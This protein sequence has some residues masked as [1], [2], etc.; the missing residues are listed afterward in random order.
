MLLAVAK[1]TYICFWYRL[2]GVV[3]AATPRTKD[4]CFEEFAAVQ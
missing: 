2:F 4:F 3:S 1:S